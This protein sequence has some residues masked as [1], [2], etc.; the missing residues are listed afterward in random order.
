MAICDALQDEELSRRT[1]YDHATYCDAH[2]LAEYR[3]IG[4]E[5]SGIQ[6]GEAMT[7]AILALVMS[8]NPMVL[9]NFL[10]YEN[11]WTSSGLTLIIWS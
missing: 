3:V 10:K 8:S 2:G 5:R 6:C 11:S 9:I 7:N 4:S 1:G